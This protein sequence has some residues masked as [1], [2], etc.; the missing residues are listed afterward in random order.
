MQVGQ[1]F[2][3]LPGSGCDSMLTTRSFLEGADC[4]LGAHL[5]CTG[6]PQPLLCNVVLVVGLLP[7]GVANVSERHWVRV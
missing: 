1:W 3:C 7:S 6:G 4:W 5:F 2:R